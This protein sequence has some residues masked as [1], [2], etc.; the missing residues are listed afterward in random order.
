MISNIWEPAV[1]AS[2]LDYDILTE[3]KELRAQC[4][5]LT[6]TELELKLTSCL[7]IKEVFHDFGKTKTRDK[8]CVNAGLNRAT[9]SMI[10]GTNDGK[11]ATEHWT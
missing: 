10:I 11:S 8:I 6:I 5:M 4:E 9:T 3:R 7:H 2:W 1:H